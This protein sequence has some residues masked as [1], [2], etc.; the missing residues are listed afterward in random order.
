MFDAF[1]GLAICATLLLGAGTATAATAPADSFCGGCCGKSAVVK[2][3]TKKDA[4]AKAEK[5][6]EAEVKKDEKKAE[7]DKKAAVVKK[8]EKKEG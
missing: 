7:T 3:Q 6:K 1:K 8:A 2:K 4:E 5:K